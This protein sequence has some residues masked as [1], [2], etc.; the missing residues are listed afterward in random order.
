M[1]LHP[2]FEIKNSTRGDETRSKLGK[3]QTWED[4]DLG[5]CRPGKIRPRES[6]MLGNTQKKNA[7]MRIRHQSV[8]CVLLLS[9]MI[10]KGLFLL[11]Y[12]SSTDEELLSQ[13]SLSTKNS[14]RNTAT[15]V[16][17]TNSLLS[18]DRVK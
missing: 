4:A 9:M 11:D 5:R 3:M 17:S 14:F 16:N 10:V 7:L 2:D 18:A 13:T 15:Y 6:A 12:I 8:T 1:V